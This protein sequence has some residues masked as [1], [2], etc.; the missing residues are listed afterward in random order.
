MKEI[1][2]V[3]IGEQGTRV[4]SQFWRMISRE[5]GLN[6]AGQLSCSSL[7]KVDKMG[8]FWE[9]SRK[10][11]ELS[12]LPRRLDVVNREEDNIERIR[13]EVERCDSLQ[14]FQVCQSMEESKRSMF[15]DIKEEYPCEI[16]HTY[17]MMSH[18]TSVENIMT[19]SDLKTF[20]DSVVLFDE[21]KV[22]DICTQNMMNHK[23]EASHLVA[24][25]MAD[26]SSLFRFPS[27]V[28]S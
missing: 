21:N 5:H 23:S 16:I 2:S 9:E 17:S 27:E 12:Y 22:K 3:N 25:V 15:E 7:D 1:I 11:Q 14:G 18:E 28:K 24:R 6:E 8:V 20:S 19:L 13:R 26:V 10:G 4:G